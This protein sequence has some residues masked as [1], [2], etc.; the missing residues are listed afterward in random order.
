MVP[1]LDAY[2]TTLSYTS[3]LGFK[4]VH[5]NDYPGYYKANRGDNGYIDGKDFE[6]KMFKFSPGNKSH[7]EFAEILDAEDNTL[8]R[9]T[10]NTALA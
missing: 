9:H 8:G 1:H 10:I 2:N 6:A 4:A 3:Q 5:A 7:R